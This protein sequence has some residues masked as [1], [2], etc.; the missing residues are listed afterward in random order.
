MIFSK[1]ELSDIFGQAI[2]EN[3]NDI[4]INSNDAK[5]GDLFIALKGEKSDGH[6]F[7]DQALNNGAALAISEK[8]IESDKIINVKSTKDALIKLAKYNIAKCSATY[9][10]VTGSVGKTTTKSL[11]YHILSRLLKNSVYTTKKNFNS[12]IGLPVCAAVMPRDT[13][14]GIFEMGMSEAGEIKKLV[15]LIPPSVSI[16]S[17][18]CEAHGEFFNSVWDIAKAKSEIFE[19]QKNREAAIIPLDSPYADFLKRRAIE[20]GIKN[21]FTFGAHSADAKIIDRQFSDNKCR[22]RAEILGTK[23]DFLCPENFLIENCLP[24]LLCAHIVSGIS[25][26]NLADEIHSFEL[27][28]GR[29]SRIYLEDRD[30]ILADD[31]YN[32]CMT[33]TKSAIKL[34]AEQKNRRKVLILGDMLELGKDEI[35]LHE[36]LSATI[37]KFETDI[38]FACGPL[39]KKLFD[40]LRDCKK[41][42]WCP[43]S[44]ELLEKVRGN[45]QNGDCILVKGS[46]STK[47]NLI[48]DA[49]KKSD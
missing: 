18:I 37:D 19:T 3:I 27:S 40:N 43:N 2:S 29:G 8:Y 36:N 46:N 7:I 1:T 6:N 11:I 31:S 25:P 45:L 38:V 34:L 33:S 22:V 35:H 48:V 39:A 16:I 41:G 10:G 9:V 42:A 4:C 5:P 26:Q 49:I 44:A 28:P 21:I 15:D 12:Q 14:I 32:A 24:A 47:M 13:K 23:T 20:N 30:I 17:K